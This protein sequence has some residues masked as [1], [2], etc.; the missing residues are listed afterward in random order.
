MSLALIKRRPYMLD[1][2]W[3][4]SSGTYNLSL[5][6]SLY[7]GFRDFKLLG[8]SIHKSY[9]GTN[10]LDPAL[11]D[12]EK[13]DNGLT[14]EP[15]S[16]GSVII[17]GKQTGVAT[18]YLG[19]YID[20]LE[21]GKTYIYDSR[22]VNGTLNVTYNDGT[23]NDYYGTIIV[24]KNRM[25][26]IRP[27]IQYNTTNSFKN[28]SVQLFPMF[29]EGN[30]IKPW[31]PAT[32][33]KPVTEPTPDLPLDVESCGYRGK[34]LFDFRTASILYSV[35]KPEMLENGFILNAS[36]QSN[37][38]IEFSCNLKAGKTY[39]MSYKTNKLS[40]NAPSVSQYLIDN[41]QYIGVNTPFIPLR[42]ITKV[43]IYIDKEYVPSKFEVTDIQIEEGNTATPYEPYSDKY[44]LDVKVTG[45][46]ILSNITSNKFIPFHALK[47]T[48]FTLITNG[49]SS[50][51]GNILFQT[52]DGH[53]YWFSIDAGQTKTTIKLSHNVIGY[54]N[55]LERKGGLKYSLVIGNTDNY[56][57]Y[58]EQVMKIAL[59]KSL[60]KG[61]RMYDNKKICD[62]LTKDGIMRSFTQ[63]TLTKDSLLDCD[64][65]QYG[66]PE[67][68]TILCRL[69]DKKIKRR[70][71]ILSK[72]LPMAENWVIEGESA[73]CSE[74]S[75]DFRLSRERLG[76]GSD[77]TVE[78]N[79]AAVIAYL[80]N[81]PLHFIVELN[82]PVFEPF[83]PET[84]AQLQSLHSE[85]GTTNMFVDSGAV[86]AG[87][88]ITYKSK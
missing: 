71:V 6:N 39:V 9:A 83:L 29:N 57:P 56:E 31:E 69:N 65:A 81:H 67:I 3:K 44:F 58:K 46:N 15:Q 14:F 36:L 40:G 37:R 5:P 41:E 26:S 24:D 4:T 68:N 45:S 20:R 32:C 25:I 59:D 86:P 35:V 74:Q 64:L 60:H 73:F 21:D 70:G 30:S 79:Q 72:E 76:L 27:Y 82:E 8:N 34:N 1:Y 42:D 51:G 17:S 22:T 18:Y 7:S 84:Q 66:A 62:M 63:I 50:A 2:E 10:L 16:D 88:E 53:D 28:G 49:V 55:M 52:E 19:E 77:T 48:T 13:T 78:E 33:G 47:G 80:T 43:G 54:F 12:A 87:I 38:I 11:Y 61:N 85:N 75:I 23:P